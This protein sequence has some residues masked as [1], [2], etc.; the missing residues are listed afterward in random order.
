MQLQL[1]TT[2]PTHHCKREIYRPTA[3]LAQ[4]RVQ[5]WCAFL[6]YF[7]LRAYIILQFFNVLTMFLISWWTELGCPVI[8]KLALHL[9]SDAEDVFIFL[10]FYKSLWACTESFHHRLQGTHHHCTRHWLCV[11]KRG[12][13]NCSKSSFLSFQNKRGKRIIK[14]DIS[15]YNI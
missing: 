1:R 2:E 5:F 11:R 10:N 15:L 4:C 8:K 9:K 7:E 6:S 13:N 3:R 12:Q 14:L